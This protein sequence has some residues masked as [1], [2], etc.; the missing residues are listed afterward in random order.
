MVRKRDLQPEEKAIW[1][2]V[3]R[4]VKPID[5]AKARSLN[6]ETI[7]SAA[8]PAKAKPSN[9]APAKKPQPV[10]HRASVDVH[11]QTRHLQAPVPVD[12]S[13]EK[14]VR[15]GKLDIDARLDLH[16]LTQEQALSTLTHFLAMAWKDGYRNVLVITGKG[17]MSR[18]R[19]RDHEPWEYPD[20]PG[21]LRRKLPEWLGKPNLRQ[22]VSGYSSAHTRHGGAGAFYV[23]L[24]VK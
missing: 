8:K 21:V 2:K 12:R 11:H 5:A 1:R 24:R 4:S 18:T 14:R 13:T 16:G 17:A 20:L 9:P 22:Y 15:R 6:D 7:A 3:A 10:K 19:E 23:T